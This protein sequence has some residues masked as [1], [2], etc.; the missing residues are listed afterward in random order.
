MHLDLLGVL[1]L[2]HGKL[3]DL[4]LVNAV[5]VL[6]VRFTMDST[7]LTSVLETSE[8]SLRADMARSRLPPSGVS[9]ET[10]ARAESQV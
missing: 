8:S 7:D 1:V 6:G 4:D 5:R 3:Q 2:Q 10:S 9:R